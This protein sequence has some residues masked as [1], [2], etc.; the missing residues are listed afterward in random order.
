MHF[1]LQQ[2]KQHAVLALQYLTCSPIKCFPTLDS[3]RRRNKALHRPTLSTVRKNNS[4]KFSHDRMRRADSSQNLGL[5][6]VFGRRL[7]LPFGKFS[8]II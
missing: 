3:Y 2:T 7:Q 5:I 8:K 4:S 1:V 6:T